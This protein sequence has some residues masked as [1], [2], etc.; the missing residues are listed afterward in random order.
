MVAFVDTTHV[1]VFY[2]DP[3]GILLLALMVGLVFG[4]IHCT[5]RKFAF[6]SHAEDAIVGQPVED[7]LTIGTSRN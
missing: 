1:A 5:G 3:R 7:E 2:V 4:G 6:P